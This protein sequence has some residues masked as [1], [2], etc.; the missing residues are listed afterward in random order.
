ME[1]GTIPPKLPLKK[2]IESKAVL[3]Q[4]IKANRALAEL[5]G[6]ARS[7]PNQSILINALSTFIYKDNISHR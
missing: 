7:I 2:D 6:S 5:K 3:K 4:I 1:V